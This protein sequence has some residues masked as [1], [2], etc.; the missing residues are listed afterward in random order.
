MNYALT[1]LSTLIARESTRLTLTNISFGDITLTKNSMSRNIKSSKIQEMHQF[2]QLWT[3]SKHY[4]QKLQAIF[5]KCLQ[6]QDVTWYHSKNKYKVNILFIQE[7]PWSVTC[8]ISS[9]SSKEGDKVVGASNHPKWINFSGSPCNEN[10]FPRVILYINIC[11]FQLCLSLQ[12]DIFNHKNICC[13]S[14]F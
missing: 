3:V 9:S 14:F 12:K 7:P 8:T 2:A 1:L 10:D 13:F 5:A 4:Y 6:E 11:L